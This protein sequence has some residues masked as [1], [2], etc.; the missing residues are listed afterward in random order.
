MGNEFDD[1]TY[2]FDPALAAAFE[3]DVKAEI[4]S[5]KTENQYAGLNA[6]LYLT[7]TALFA[8]G[9]VQAL[10]RFPDQPLI[11]GGTAAASAIS[12]YNAYASAGDMEHPQNAQFLK[13]IAASGALAFVLYNAVFYDRPDVDFSMEEGQDHAALIIEAE[14]DVPEIPT[15]SLDAD[16]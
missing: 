10:E 16:F 6:G 14:N 8:E 9:T 7:T 11:A 15:D 13:G 12:A 5:R 4:Q 2:A 1:E 3:R